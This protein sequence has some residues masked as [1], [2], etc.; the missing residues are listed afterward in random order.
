VA[1]SPAVEEACL[2]MLRVR[3][4]AASF[5]EWKRVIGSRVLL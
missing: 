1:V 5:G 2:R 3:V 4:E